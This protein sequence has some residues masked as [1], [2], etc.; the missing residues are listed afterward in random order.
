MSWAML[1]NTKSLYCWTKLTTTATTTVVLVI[2]LSSVNS[3][4]PG[5]FQFNF[6]KVNF[7]LIIVNGGWC[8]SYEIA[9]RWM[10]QDLTDDSQHWFRLWLGAVR[11]EANTWADVG[12]DLCRR[13]APQGL[14]ELTLHGKLRLYCDLHC[15]Q[16]QW[17]YCVLIEHLIKA[18]VTV[19]I[20]AHLLVDKQNVQLMPLLVIQCFSVDYFWWYA[21]SEWWW[22]NLQPSK[23]CLGHERMHKHHS[24]LAPD[25]RWYLH[26]HINLSELLFFMEVQFK[27]A[28]SEFETRNI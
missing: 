24:L 17:Y 12:P 28:F 8:I 3:L 7:K 16:Q 23:Y 4:A 11:Q 9:L 15:F 1:C 26:S 20:H 10:P 13:M 2:T 14:N 21:Y 6:R 18:I 25:S 22:A 19:A 27:F 5:R